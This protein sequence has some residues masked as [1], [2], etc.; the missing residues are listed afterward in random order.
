MQLI[1]IIIQCQAFSKYL[2]GG[3]GIV[4]SNVAQVARVVQG[5]NT[6]VV[7]TADL[8]AVDAAV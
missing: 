7:S 1:K 8:E 3:E 6:H 5:K 2:T 4:S